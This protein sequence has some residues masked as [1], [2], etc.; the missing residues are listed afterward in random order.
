MIDAQGYRHDLNGWLYEHSI[1]LLLLLLLTLPHKHTILL[2]F[3]AAGP[4]YLVTPLILDILKEK[5]V[6]ATFFISGEGRGW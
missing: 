6:K 1:I 4:H 5:K 3:A 2:P